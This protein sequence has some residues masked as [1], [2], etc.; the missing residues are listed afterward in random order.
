MYKSYSANEYKK[1]LNLPDE[2][3]IDGFL[4]FGTW[5]REGQIKVLKAV[6]D[7]LNLEYKL[8]E[9]PNFLG[10][11]VEI[12]TQGKKLWF[13]VAYGGAMLS[14][15]THL[16][17]L[18]ESKTNILIGSCGGLSTELESN[19]VIL[20]DYSHGDGSS[21]SMYQREIIDNLYP[22]SEEL[23]GK[24]SVELSK[25]EIPFAIGNTIT[26]QAIIGETMEDI[27]KWNK[28]GF[29]GVEMEA[30]TLFSV[31]NHFN[32]NS[33]AMVYIADNLIKEETFHSESFAN[34]KEYRERIRDSLYEIAI[35][36][37]LK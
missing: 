24:L 22:S 9:L 35:K 20:P 15:F 33:A 21:A 29:V 36:E 1:I 2:Y 27:I 12:E 8:N 30:A 25:L 31:S 10:R 23:R 5:D 34:S 37:L 7:R 14:V 18:F 4:V 19:T 6:L 3:K 26:C 32:V 13:D 17:C 11:M 16:A 28:Q